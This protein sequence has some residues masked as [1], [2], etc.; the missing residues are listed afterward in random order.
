MGGIAE[1]EADAAAE[2]TR[3]KEREREQRGK[4]GNPTVSGAGRHKQHRLPTAANFT[5]DEGKGGILFYVGLRRVLA[6][7]AHPPTEPD[8]GP[9]QG[10][11][12]GAVS[13]TR[14]KKQST[15]RGG[16]GAAPRP[17]GP[18]LQPRPKSRA[19]RARDCTPSQATAG[20][21][22]GARKEGKG[23]HRPQGGYPGAEG[24]RGQLLHGAL[25]TLV[26]ILGFLLSS[27]Y[28]RRSFD[29][30]R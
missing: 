6:A 23:R 29:G 20:G 3:G 26:A 8:P 9:V 5:K 17:P 22:A 7:L 30:E 1:L 2:Q 14:R 24:G 15:K 11:W 27:M 16:T 21:P 10:T 12:W 18:S 13:R 25:L 4:G 19:L 28:T